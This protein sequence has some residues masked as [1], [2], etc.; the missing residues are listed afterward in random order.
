[1]NL[2]ETIRRILREEFENKY[3][4]SMDE[5]VSE[6]ART[7]KNARQQGVGLRFPKSA[8]KSNPNRFRPYSREQVDETDPKVGTGK[9]PK[10]SSRRLYTDENP[11][12]TVSVKFRTKEDII[13][14]LNKESFKSKPHKRQSQII[15]LIHQRVR[16]ALENAKDPETKKRLKRAFDYI[17]IQKEKSKEKTK[18]L[19]EDTMSSPKIKL[20]QLIE[21]QSLREVVKMMGVDKVSTILETTPLQLIRDFFLDKTFSID[22]FNVNTGE[23]DFSFEITDIDEEGDDVWYVYAKIGDGS[24]MLMT[25]EDN[26]QRDLW[27]S[28]LWDEDYWWEIQGEI[29]EINYDILLPFVPENIDIKVEHNLM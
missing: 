5:E 22:D 9:K 17:E 6:Y 26:E 8:I 3:D 10:G 25:D 13:D 18:R 21:R 7:L 16:V 28:G 4:T 15:N 19:Q 14:T 1:M 2:Q 12:D 11:K 20:E 23:Y 24:V 29:M 27:N